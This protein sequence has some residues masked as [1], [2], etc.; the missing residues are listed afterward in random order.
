VKPIALLL[1]LALLLAACGE[2]VTEP[3]PLAVSHP[4]DTAQLG[5]GPGTATLGAAAALQACGARVAVDEVLQRLN[6]ARAS[7]Y[8]CGGRA[9]APAAPL[10]WDASLYS[11]AEVHSRDMARRNYFEHR[12]PEGVDVKSRASAAH[13]KFRTLGENIAAG[14]RTLPEAMQAWMESA[15]HCE[16]IMAP[17]FQDVAVACVAQPG[18]E[19]GTYWTMVLGRK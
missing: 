7:G 6:A 8:R 19:W 5:A 16:N 1:P 2:R 14:V 3:P 12:T 10:H 11:A 15:G 9:M 4:P 17:E 18:S 13:Y